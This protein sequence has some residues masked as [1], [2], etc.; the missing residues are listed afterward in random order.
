MGDERFCHLTVSTLGEAAWATGQALRFSLQS[1]LSLHEAWA[2]AT[3]VSE[4][5]TNA[6]KY[7]AGGR[8]SMRRPA[9]PPACVEVLIEDDGPGMRA[10]R[11]AHP[12]RGLGQGLEAVGRLMD[13]LVVRDRVPHGTLARC[14]KRHRPGGDRWDQEPCAIA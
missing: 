4:L 12:H 14:L 11:G 10:T 13:E 2:V 1:G 7:A 8:L 5:V 6:V 3:A 9:G